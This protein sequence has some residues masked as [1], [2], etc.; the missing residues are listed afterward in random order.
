[1]PKNHERMTVRLSREHLSALAHLTKFTSPF[2][3]ST[4]SPSDTIRRLIQKALFEHDPALYKQL[5]GWR[6]PTVCDV[7]LR[8][9]PTKPKKTRSKKTK[10]T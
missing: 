8:S 6:V 3:L 10:P 5:F 7:P 9:E 1:M 2:Y 4:R